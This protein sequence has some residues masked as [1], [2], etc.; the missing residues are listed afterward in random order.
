MQR[1][2]P[3]ARMLTWSLVLLL[4]GLTGCTAVPRQEAA[5]Q[6][7]QP[8]PPRVRIEGSGVQLP[9]ESPGLTPVP[10]EFC[11]LL[12]SIKGWPQVPRRR[13]G[14]GRRTACRGTGIQAIAS[15][16][17]RWNELLHGGLLHLTPAR[18]E[19]LPAASTFDQPIYSWELLVIPVTATGTPHLSVPP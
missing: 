18:D 2:G 13:G 19:W 16:C 4:V 1:K 12:G 3:C 15:S 9:A 14:A 7:P 11:A 6:P 17:G 8:S 5:A 10:R